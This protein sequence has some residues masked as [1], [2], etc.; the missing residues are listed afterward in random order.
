MS[1]VKHGG[2]RIM[3]WGCFGALETGGLAH[4]NVIM[5]SATYQ[6]MLNENITLSVENLK[7]GRGWIMQQDNNPKRTSRSTQA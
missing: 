1:T 7:L 2:G 3:V 4:I 5:N 6:D